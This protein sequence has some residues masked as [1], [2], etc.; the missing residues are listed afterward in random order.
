M[1]FA[2]QGFRYPIRVARARAVATALAVPGLGAA[3]VMAPVKWLRQ[4]S[5]CRL[6]PPHRR[7]QQPV[8]GQVQLNFRWQNRVFRWV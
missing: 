4:R 7:G 6:A 5:R 1:K 2:V 3:G 8:P